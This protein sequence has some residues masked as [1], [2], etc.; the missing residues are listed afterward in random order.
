L[1]N[2]MHPNEWTQ[3]QLEDPTNMAVKADLFDQTVFGV[4]DPTNIEVGEQMIFQLVN[5]TTNASGVTTRNIIWSGTSFVN[6][7]SNSTYGVLAANTGQFTAGN[8]P[9]NGPQF[10][11]CSYNGASYS[12]EYD[13]KIRQVRLLGTVLDGFTT[14]PTL[15]GT[16]VQFYNSSNTL[17]DS[18]TVQFDG[19]IRASVPSN[20]TSFTVV[21]DTL[22]STY[23]RLF[24]YNTVS[25]DASVVSCFAP[26]P[27]NLAVGTTT[28]SAPILVSPRIKG[29]ATPA[30]TGCTDSQLIKR[31]S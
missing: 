9:T 19:S 18:V 8:N 5:Y 4:Q 20:T 22:P 7:D 2:V 14:L 25:Y 1:T 6:S 27:S 24:F 29:E 26:T 10:V 16:Q 31:R 3:Q 21:G 28:M 11:T 23:Y 13:I 30:A 12:T 15:A 17:V